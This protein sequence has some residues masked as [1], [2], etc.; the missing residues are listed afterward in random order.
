MQRANYASYYPRLQLIENITTG[1]RL[2]ATLPTISE[3]KNTSAWVR[4]KEEWTHSLYFHLPFCETLCWFC[5][6]TDYDLDKSRGDDYLDLLEKE[7]VLY[8]RIASSCRTTALW[9][10]SQFFG[11]AQIDRPAALIDRHQPVKMRNLLQLDPRRLSFPQVEALP[12]WYYPSFFWVQDCV[13]KSK[14]IH[15]IQPQSDNN[16]AM[17]LLRGM[18]SVPPTLI[19][20][21]D[22]ADPESLTAPLTMFWHSNESASSF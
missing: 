12:E 7:L 22:S 13:L 15:R 10:Y 3:H 4:S 20:Y 11:A 17:E 18:A 19:L 2:P 5:G 9:W 6:C 1:L 14:A 21:T 16:K 8:E